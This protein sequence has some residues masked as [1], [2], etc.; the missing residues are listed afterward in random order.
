[1]LCALQA[2]AAKDKTVSVILTHSPRVASPYRLAQ[3]P[4]AT[5]TG[6]VGG[7]WFIRFA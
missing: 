3:T 7:G 2:E 6:K 1:M 4:E 5:F